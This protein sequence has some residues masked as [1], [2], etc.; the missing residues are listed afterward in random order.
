MELLLDS[1]ELLD[2][3]DNLQ[4]VSVYCQAGCCWLTQAGD[5]RD[6]ILHAGQSHRIS[7]RGKVM[8]TAT[9]AT[10]LQLIAA[11]ERNQVP[12]PWRQFCCTR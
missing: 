6:H 10:R 2:L 4:Q 1:N 5:S 3:G 7:M 11:Q 12:L 8:V 9:A